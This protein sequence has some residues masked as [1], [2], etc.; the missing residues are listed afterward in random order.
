MHLGEKNLVKRSECFFNF[1]FSQR[2]KDIAFILTISHFSINVRS[3]WALK[4]R[5]SARLEPGVWGERRWEA[6]VPREGLCSS[7]MPW[8]RRGIIP[9]WLTP[10]NG[11]FTKHCAAFG[12]YIFQTMK[13]MSEIQNWCFSWQYNEWGIYIC[14]SRLELAWD[15]SSVPIV[16]WVCEKT[17][18][19]AFV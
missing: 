18:S 8:S 15:R 3:C 1:L 17:K 6:C 4:I 5:E 10:N 13:V 14:F 12:L 2:G 19:W 9:I 16:E 7:S 11:T